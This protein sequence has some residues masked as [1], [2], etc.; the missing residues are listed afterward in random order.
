MRVARLLAL[1]LLIAVTVSVIGF[2]LTEGLLAATK[3]VEPVAESVYRDFDSVTGVYR[4]TLRGFSFQ[5]PAGW[6]G[7]EFSGEE[8]FNGSDSDF[9]PSVFVIGVVYDSPG[10]DAKSFVIETNVGILEGETTGEIV[11]SGALESAS[12]TTAY[13]ESVRYDN[14]SGTTVRIDTIGYERGSHLVTL[15]VIAVESNYTSKKVQIDQLVESFTWEVPAPYGASQSDSLFLAV[16][17]IRTIDPV[18]F[19]GS[20]DSIV[21]E[22][23]SGLVI[24]NTDLEVAPDLALSWDVDATGT[25][26][27]FHIDPLAVFHDGRQITAEDV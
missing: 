8:F 26:Y 15:L 20:A 10:Q 9:T 13:R 24:L 14:S 11:S 1:F 4:D 16:G 7:E 23:F 12:G 17:E 25:V 22:L 2:D 3:P 5:M 19:R 18:L 21:G 27:T 6:I